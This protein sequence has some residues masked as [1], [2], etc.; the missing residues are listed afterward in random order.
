MGV[1]MYPLG[2]Q[3]IPSSI[4]HG[5]LIQDVSKAELFEKGTF[6]KKILSEQWW[7]LKH[8]KFCK[9]LW[10]IAQGFKSLF[11]LTDTG[12]W[13]RFSLKPSAVFD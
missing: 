9:R 7:A 4:W 2:S 11:W 8:K 1:Y 5:N 13:F 6:K 12:Q 3:N 10:S